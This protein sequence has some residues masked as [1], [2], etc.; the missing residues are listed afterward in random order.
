MIIAAGRGASAGHRGKG[1]GCARACL[2]SRHSMGW[3][4]KRP[5]WNR[6]LGPRA[7]ILRFVM[8]IAVAAAGCSKPAP[9]PPPPPPAVT[10]ARPVQREVIE[11]DEYTGRLEASQLVE[12]RARVSGYLEEA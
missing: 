3:D 10:V 1:D 6:W 11:W 7:G 9:P 2:P 8:S 5:M 12:V 4:G